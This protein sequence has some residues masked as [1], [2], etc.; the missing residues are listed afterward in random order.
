MRERAVPVDAPDFTL[1]NTDGEP[2]RLSDFRGRK[3]V[4]LALLRGFR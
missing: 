1:T 2:V 4:L 3:H